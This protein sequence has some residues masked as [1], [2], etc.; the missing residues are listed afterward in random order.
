MISFQGMVINKLFIY[1][2]RTGGQVQFNKET[3]WGNETFI[4]ILL[5]L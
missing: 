5:V 4:L 3:A 1:K 2:H